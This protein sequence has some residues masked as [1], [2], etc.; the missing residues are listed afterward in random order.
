MG[1]IEIA[2][3][4]CAGLAM[5]KAII[6]DLGLLRPFGARNDSGAHDSS[7]GNC[8]L[9]VYLLDFDVVTCYNTTSFKMLTPNPGG[10][11]ILF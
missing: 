8:I 11:A 7:Y 5:T 3:A 9:V 2:T 6:M 10:A 1:K 4:C